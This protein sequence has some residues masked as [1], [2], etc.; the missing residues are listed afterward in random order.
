MIP[1][2]ARLREFTHHEFKSG[3]R[4]FVCLHSPDG[5]AWHRASVRAL[6]PQPRHS[7]RADGIEVQLDGEKKWRLLPAS[8]VRALDAVERLAELDR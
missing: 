4:V 1:A 7:S 3:D 2:A 8:C 5:L 6:Y